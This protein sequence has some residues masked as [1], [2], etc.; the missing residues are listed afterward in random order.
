MGLPELYRL[1]AIIDHRAG[2]PAMESALRYA[3]RAALDSGVAMLATRTALSAAEICLRLNPM[4]RF[5]C[6]ITSF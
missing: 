3:H 2:R 5:I 1:R 6:A 4:T